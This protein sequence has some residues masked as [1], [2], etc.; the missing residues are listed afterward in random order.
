[1]IKTDWVAILNNTQNKRILFIEDYP[2]LTQTL[3]IKIKNDDIII[4]KH[5]LVNANDKSFKGDIDIYSVDD[6]QNIVNSWNIS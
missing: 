6:E 2:S 4:G 1:M 3:A 5:I